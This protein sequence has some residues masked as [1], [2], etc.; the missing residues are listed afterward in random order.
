METFWRI[1]TY[2]LK[3]LRMRKSRLLATTE[4]LQISWHDIKLNLT[5]G[6][7]FDKTFAHN[8]INLVSWFFQKHIVVCKLNIVLLPNLLHPNVSIILVWKLVFEARNCRLE[9]I[10]RKSHVITIMTLSIDPIY[11]GVSSMLVSN[12]YHIRKCEIVC[13]NE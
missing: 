10:C 1:Y 12:W 13:I 4:C 2:N 3:H 9:S 5:L 8:F 7:L 6:I 11:Q